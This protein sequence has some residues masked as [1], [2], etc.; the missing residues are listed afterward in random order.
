MF[1]R[2]ATR[3]HRLWENAPPA[4]DLEASPPLSW[5]TATP[6]GITPRS[7]RVPLANSLYTY[8]FGATAK[9]HTHSLDKLVINWS[10][11]FA[12]KVETTIIIVVTESAQNIRKKDPIVPPALTPPIVLH[13]RIRLMNSCSNTNAL[14]GK[15]DFFLHQEYGSTDR[16][17]DWCRLHI[18][19]ERTELVAISRVDKCIGIHQFYQLCVH[20]WHWTKSLSHV[21]NVYSIGKGLIWPADSGTT[22]CLRF[23]DTMFVMSHKFAANNCKW[24]T[25]WEGYEDRESRFLANQSYRVDVTIVGTQVCMYVYLHHNSLSIG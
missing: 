18:V 9:W 24:P 17:V 19:Y 8:A 5:K 7:G 3:R 13:A 21:G 23:Q 6:G 10:D 14:Q 2:V 12:G 22:H 20:Q 4:Q 16:K 15:T 25:T 11:S 1:A